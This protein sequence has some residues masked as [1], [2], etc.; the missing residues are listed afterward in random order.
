MKIP[1]AQ[2]LSESRARTRA[3]RFWRWLVP[4]LLVLLFLAVL[5]WL[6]WQARQMESTERADQ[7]NHGRPTW[8]QLD[9]AALDK[10]FLRGQ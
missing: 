2:H 4:M 1:F 8:V 5:I 10:L 6:P 3:W 7:C 9:I